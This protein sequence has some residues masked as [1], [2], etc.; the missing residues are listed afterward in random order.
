MFKNF[1]RDFP[2]IYLKGEGDEFRQKGRL[3]YEAG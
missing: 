1:I 3:N 2:G